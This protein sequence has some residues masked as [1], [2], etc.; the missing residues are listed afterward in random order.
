MREVKLLR[1]IE[2]SVPCERENL[3][4]RSFED[5]GWKSIGNGEAINTHINVE[6]RILPIE[7]FCKVSLSPNPEDKY[8]SV[9]ENYGY[10][11]NSRSTYTHTTYVA[12]DPSQSPFLTS[13]IESQHKELKEMVRKMDTELHKAEGL[14]THWEG[15][16]NTLNSLIDNSSF[17]TRLKYLFT[18]RLDG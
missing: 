1:I 17:W 13:W 6:E 15:N 10:T 5:T 16:C 3:I 9:H 11:G 2:E 18:G 12:V 7:R 4:V 8:D 14:K